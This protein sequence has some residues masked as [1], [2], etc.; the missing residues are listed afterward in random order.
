MMFSLA[1]SGGLPVL[2][3]VYAGSGICFQLWRHSFCG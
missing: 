1:P 2:A 3:P